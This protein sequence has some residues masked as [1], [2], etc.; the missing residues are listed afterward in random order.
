MLYDSCN[1]QRQVVVSA[2][3]TVK[4]ERGTEQQQQ[5][6]AFSQVLL[7]LLLPHAFTAV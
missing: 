1:C 6:L 2:L 5:Q 3:I 4:L 7:L